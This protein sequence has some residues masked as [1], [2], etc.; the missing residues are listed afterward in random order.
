MEPTTTA[1]GEPTRTAP[2]GDR[3][4]VYL[5]NWSSARSPGHHGPGRV[6]SI[7]AW[8]PGWEE[9]QVPDLAPHRA[10]LADIRAGRIG[11]PEYERR[12]RERLRPFAHLA[13]GELRLAD[14]SPVRDGDTL[15]CSCSREAAAAGRCHRV[16]AADVLRVQRW[17]VILDG[18]LL[19]PANFLG[20][21]RWGQATL[22][23]IDDWVDGWHHGPGL[24]PLSI[25][26][27][28]TLGQYAR[29]VEDPD[30]LE[31]I[32][33]E[34]WPRTAAPR[35]PSLFGVDAPARGC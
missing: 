6:L 23:E 3:P 35:Q 27:G 5:S 4:T 2:A 9:G 22:D 33:A 29:W 30:A 14:G 16:P 28:M 15:C 8:S 10:D 18:V 20:A 25:H 19:F 12:Y 7:Q 31:Q 34:P 21:V 1:M 26:L 17:R 11:W 32:A 24:F 13:P